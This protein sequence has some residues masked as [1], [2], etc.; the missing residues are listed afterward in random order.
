[1][2][3]CIASC[4]VGAR[5]LR[6]SARAARPLGRVEGDTARYLSGLDESELAREISYANFA[7]EIWTYPLWQALMHQVN[8]A[9]QH[10]SEVALLLTEAGHSPSDLDF[11]RY[12]DALV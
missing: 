12:F 10:R 11:L 9:T 4:A 1:M 2:A 8:H 3:G 5:G 6:R 7:G